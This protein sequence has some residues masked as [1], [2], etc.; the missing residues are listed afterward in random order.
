MFESHISAGATEK[1]IRM[2]QTSLENFSV[3]LRHGWTCLKMRGT[4]LR[5]GKSKRK[6]W[7]IK[8]DCQKF[9]PILYEESL[10]LARIGRPGI[11]WSVNK[12]ARPIR[13]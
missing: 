6:I 9:A 11:L 13:K 8:V 2:G 1:I 3:V 4:V 10:Y 7:K 12:L 5:I